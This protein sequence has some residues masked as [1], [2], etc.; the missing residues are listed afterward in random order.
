M[1]I[2][3]ITGITGQDGSYLAELLLEK[4]TLYME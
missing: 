2:A 1:K 3:F 4:N